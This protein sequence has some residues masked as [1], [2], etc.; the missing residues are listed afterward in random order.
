M[1][2]SDFE[3]RDRWSSDRDND[4]SNYPNENSDPRPD[5]IPEKHVSEHEN[6]EYPNE[7]E[8]EQPSEGADTSY[9]EKTD[10]TPPNKR[11]F[12]SVG[13]VETDFTPGNHGRTTGRMVGH[14]P[15]TEGI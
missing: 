1:I 10:V 9:S 2:T 5:E 7:T 14:E 6:S 15:G 8:R 13:N 4:K 11:E 12:P 3:D